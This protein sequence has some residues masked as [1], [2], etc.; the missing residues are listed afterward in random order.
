MFFLC[1]RWRGAAADGA[2]AD[3]RSCAG[4]LGLC[5]R[6]AAAVAHCP[7]LHS[8]QCGMLQAAAGVRGR[9][10]RKHHRPQADS[11]F[12][13]VCWRH[14]C[15]QIPAIPG[16]PFCFQAAGCACTAPE[17]GFSGNA[18]AHLGRCCAGSSR[19]SDRY[20]PPGSCC[21]AAATA[22]GSCIAFAVVRAPVALQAM[23]RASAR[24]PA[25][26]PARA[27]ADGWLFPQ[28]CARMA[29]LQ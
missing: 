24:R 13:C 2:S 17:T 18:P 29:T 14:A 15:S 26:V 23:Q 3:K 19:P 28:R 7:S 1:L 12:H 21:N 20:R 5:H 22:A 25:A 6:T 9:R 8:I 10:L 27:G 11:A 4:L 16:L